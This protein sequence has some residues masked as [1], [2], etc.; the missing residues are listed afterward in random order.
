MHKGQGRR[1][2]LDD[3][4]LWALRRHCITYQH[5]SLIDITKWAQEYFQKPLS[6]NMVMDVN[7]VQKRRHVLWVKVHLKWTVSKWK[8]VPWSDESKF[9]IRV[10][11]HGCRVLWPKEDEDLPACYQHSVKNTASLMVSYLSTLPFS[12]RISCIS[13][14]SSAPSLLL[15]LPGNSR[16]LYGPNLVTWILASIFYSKVVQSPDL[17]WN[18][19]PHTIDTILQISN[20]LWPQPGNLQCALLISAQVVDAGSWI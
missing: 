3:R 14:P 1:S 20:H 9:D 5:D 16:N 8:R 10:G 2:L 18:T 4:D 6:V 12:P 7:M 17:I 11:N 19:S 15:F 13:H